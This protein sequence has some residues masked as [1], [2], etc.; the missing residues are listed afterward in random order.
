M[1]NLYKVISETEKELIIEDVTFDKI[2]ELFITA[3]N[4]YNRLLN[5]YDVLVNHNWYKIE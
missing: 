5:G 3:L 1:K 4:Q 2:N